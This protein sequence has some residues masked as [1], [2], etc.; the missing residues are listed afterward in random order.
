[1]TEANRALDA[2]RDAVELRARF[3]AAHAGRVVSRIKLAAMRDDER[4]AR[5]ALE[6][7][8]RLAVE[9]LGAGPAAPVVWPELH[10]GAH[11]FQSPRRP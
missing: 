8:F 1:M 2:Y 4:E 11:G 9:G 6:E 7:A 5:A 10:G 3:E